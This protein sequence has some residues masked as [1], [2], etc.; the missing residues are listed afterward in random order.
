MNRRTN[1]LAAAVIVGGFSLLDEPP[2]ASATYLDPFRGTDTA[3]SYC[4][5]TGRATRC[6]AP[7]GCTTHDGVCLVMR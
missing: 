4:C 1:F 3:I 6:C 7:T 2:T 5:S